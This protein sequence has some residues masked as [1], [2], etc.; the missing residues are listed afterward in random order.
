MLVTRIIIQARTGSTRLPG[1]VLRPLG[2]MSV[3]AW[4]VRA[5]LAASDDV[6]VAT[7]ILEADDAVAA[8]AVRNG[9]RV[10]R[11]PVDDVLTRYLLATESFD[12]VVVRLTADC[13]LADPQVI[14][15]CVELHDATGVDYVS[16]RDVPRGLDAE[17]FRSDTLRSVGDVAEGVD[18]VH[19]TSAMYREGS[20]LTVAHL[21]LG[22][23]LSRYRVTL[24]TPQ[25]AAAL[26][27]IVAELGPGISSWR[28]IVGLLERRPDL[29]A[30]NASVQQKAIHEG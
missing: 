25:D 8:E 2:S 16:T 23:G 12:G 3:L 5:A 24:D 20:A 28:S 10:V 6:W 1:K 27:A 21:D 29:V 4:V 7:T 9:A 18:R 13:P 15:A 17:V 11:G 26:D 22:A 14:K 30:L 19:V